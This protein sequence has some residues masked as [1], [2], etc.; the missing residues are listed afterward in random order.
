MSPIKG[1]FVSAM[2]VMMMVM[3]MKYSTY[4]P[5]LLKVRPLSIKQRDPHGSI[6][7]PLD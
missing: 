2:S 3:M 6:T 7:S 4:L 5:R 1:P